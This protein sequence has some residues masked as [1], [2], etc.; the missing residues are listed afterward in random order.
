MSMAEL[1][2]SLLLSFNSRFDLMVRHQKRQ[3]GLLYVVCHQ[4]YNKSILFLFV[5]GRGC[6][7]KSVS[8]FYRE[9]EWILFSENV[10]FWFQKR[11]ACKLVTI[12][13]R[14]SK[15]LRHNYCQSFLETWRPE[16]HNMGLTRCIGQQPK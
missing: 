8:K 3:V 11:Q 2:L 15:F 1:V 4:E 14:K 13:K 5:Y 6:L 9:T 12:L 16:T 10:E 7:Q